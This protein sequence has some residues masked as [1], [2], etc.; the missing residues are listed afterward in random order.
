MSCFCLNEYY[1][2]PRALEL[3]KQTAEPR[4]SPVDTVQHHK[5]GLVASDKKSRSHPMSPSM[6]LKSGKFVQQPNVLTG[7]YRADALAFRN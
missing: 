6:A 1:I 7:V 2:D 4:V 5:L 3:S